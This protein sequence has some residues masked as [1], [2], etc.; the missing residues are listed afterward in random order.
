MNLP[1]ATS[2]KKRAIDEL[3]ARSFVEDIL[4]DVPPSTRTWVCGDFN[5]RVG[6]CSPCVGKH[7]L[8]R[9]SEDAVVCARAQWLIQ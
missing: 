6:T 8:L 4:A 9:Q 7:A 2:L 1:P 3:V 5:T